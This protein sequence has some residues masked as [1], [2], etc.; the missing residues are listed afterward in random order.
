MPHISGQL[1]IW[2]KKEMLSRRVVGIDWIE[3]GRWVMLAVGADVVMRM[4]QR[5]TQIFGVFLCMGVK[6]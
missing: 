3:W 4:A 2:G 5:K 1:K 6:S